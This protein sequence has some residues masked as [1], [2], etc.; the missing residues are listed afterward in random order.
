MQIFTK[1]KTSLYYFTRYFLAQAIY[2][3]T[4]EQMHEVEMHSC[5]CRYK[6]SYT[7][8]TNSLI[9]VNFY[10]LKW[11]EKWQEKFFHELDEANSFFCHATNLF[12]KI[13]AQIACIFAISTQK[14]LHVIYSFAFQ[15]YLASR[16]QLA[17]LNYFY[18]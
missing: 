18:L 10:D 6:L 16:G 1:K 13:A 2:V 4:E 12:F 8:R 11:E 14:K 15:P 3:Y 9:R 5:G 7:P 17:P